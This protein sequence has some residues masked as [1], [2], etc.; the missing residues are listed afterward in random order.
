MSPRELSSTL[1]LLG[2]SPETKLLVKVLR[3]YCVGDYV[4]FLIMSWYLFFL[5]KRALVLY[6]SI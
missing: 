4:V 6:L 2:F 5:F 3:E 1:I